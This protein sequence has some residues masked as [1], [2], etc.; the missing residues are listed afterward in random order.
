MK[1]IW[2]VAVACAI[3]SGCGGKL[4]K[5]DLQS[6]QSALEKAVELEKAGSYAEASPLVDGAIT[7]GGLN[8]DQLSE[9]Y[10]VRAR[11]LCMAGKLEEAERDLGL[12]E[13]GA[14][15]PL[16]G[17]SVERFCLPNKTRLLNP[18]PNSRKPSRSIQL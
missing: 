1:P 16:A 7:K 5:D 14:P 13:Q 4:S 9:A 12:A 6:A 10:L 15:N 11:C 17:T 3:L 8:P 18:R 2:I